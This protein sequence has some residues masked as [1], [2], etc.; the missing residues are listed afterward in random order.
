MHWFLK[1]VL[2]LLSIFIIGFFTVFVRP[3]LFGPKL[4]SNSEKYGII[5]Q[6]ERWSGVI[7]V[8][9]DLYAI[10]GTK[11]EVLQGT[12]ILVSPQGDRS[13]LDF[14]PKHSKSG[15]N[16]SGEV[17]D[18]IRPGEPFLD[19]KQKIS[20]RLWDL[21]IKGSR[22]Q[23][24]SLISSADHKSPYD[25][26]KISIHSGILIKVNFAG[27][28][29][30]EIG[31]NT[32]VRDSNF[33][34]IGECAVCIRSGNPTILNNTFTKTLRD[35]IWVDRASPRITHNL[36]L[37]S[38]G[39]GIVVNPGKNGH[40][41]ISNNEFQLPN[42][43]AVLFLTGDERLGGVIVKNLFSSGDIGLPCDSRVEILQNH[44]KSN[45]TFLKSGNCVGSFLVGLNYW[46]INDPDQVVTSRVTGTEV[47]FKVNLNGVLRQP[48]KD[49]GR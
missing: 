24:V 41:E 37:S 25:F 13:N 28:R 45:L 8:T 10:P 9:G 39:N 20:I 47:S 29:R 1:L 19:E 17:D 12:Q 11:V 34:E 44:I 38:K 26:N 33:T 14:N 36:F 27:F 31:S 5:W 40:P 16:S 3:L 49:V 15:V 4:V 23:P 6:N 18:Q 7:R 42:Y 43:F 22:E 30:L 2:V 21:E 35:Y 48:P 32:T 46:E